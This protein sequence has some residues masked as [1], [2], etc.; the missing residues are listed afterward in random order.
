MR[1]SRRVRDAPLLAASVMGMGYGGEEMLMEGPIRL[2][3][4]LIRP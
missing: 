4:Q 3:Q 1:R 2:H